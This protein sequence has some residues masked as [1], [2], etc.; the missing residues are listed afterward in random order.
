[1]GR[2]GLLQVPLFLC[3]KALI[4]A[5]WVF[6]ASLRRAEVPS[7]AQPWSSPFSS[8]S[9]GSMASGS[10]L[11]EYT[12]AKSRLYS[13]CHSVGW[14]VDTLV[15]SSKVKLEGIEVQFCVWLD[16]HSVGGRRE[17]EMPSSGSL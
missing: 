11:S 6:L 13:L 12:P 1:M 17:E 15:V 8:C 2:V 4:S 9:L 10:A 5:S 7:G 16:V 3:W 14:V